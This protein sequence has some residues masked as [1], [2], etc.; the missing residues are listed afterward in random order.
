MFSNITS[1]AVAAN[2]AFVL[3]KDARTVYV[4][5]IGNGEVVAEYKGDGIA[6]GFEPTA[7]TALPRWL[8]IADE[9]GK[10]ILRLKII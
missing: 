6:G 5:S 10:R 3:D 9:A 4:L 1:L 2:F 7:I 8:F